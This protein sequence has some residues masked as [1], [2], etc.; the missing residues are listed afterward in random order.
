MK[1]ITILLTTLLLCTGICFATDATD[2]TEVTIT[3]PE[4]GV[5]IHREYKRQLIK[6]IEYKEWGYKSWLEIPKGWH[7]VD[8]TANDRVV[9]IVLEAD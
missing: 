2:T 8:I 5:N 7:V 6:V 1:K 9:I 3:L 4:G